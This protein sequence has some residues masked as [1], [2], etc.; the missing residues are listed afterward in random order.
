MPKRAAA[1]AVEINFI[2][3]LVHANKLSVNALVC[4]AYLSVLAYSFFSRQDYSKGIETVI[5]LTTVKAMQKAI[6]KARTV[7]PF[8][9]INCFGSYSVTNKQTGAT[10]T[11]ECL[12]QGGRRFAHCSCKAGARAQV[13]FHLAAAVGVHIVLAARLAEADNYLADLYD[14]RD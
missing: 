13:C 3:P 5:Q 9:R 4:V 12:K 10:Y 11:V 7:K 14:P 8:V 2:I 1:S 6:D